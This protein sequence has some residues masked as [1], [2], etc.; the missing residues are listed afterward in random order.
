MVLES[1]PHR[2]LSREVTK[3]VESGVRL[4]YRS[5]RTPRARAILQVQHQLSRACRHFLDSKGFMEVLAPIIGPVT[6]PGIRGAGTVIV[7]FY[8]KM[9]VLMTS[10]ILYK[11]MTM[12]SY[13]RVYSFSPNV[14]LEPSTSKST[15]RHLAEFY[16]LDLEMA[17]TSCDEVMTFG[18]TLL[19]EVIHSVREKCKTQLEQLGRTLHLPPRTLPRITFT[20]ALDILADEGF[21]LDPKAEIPWMAEHH[22]SLYFDSPFWITDYPITSRGFYYLVDDERPEIVRS[23]DLLLPEGY[24]ELSSGGEREYTVERVT[25]RMRDTGEDPRKYGWYLDMLEE[26]IPP[27]AGFGIGMERLTRYICGT[28]HIWE[29]SPFPKVPGIT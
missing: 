2:R 27:S 4:R 12:A 22:L 15:G 23:M 18:D 13:P 5:I 26:G 11:Q 20:E 16:Q 7:P 8:G 17:H 19:F 9:Y 28:P 1:I 10:M 29:C 25:R 14:R 6:D 24:G 21:D 3:D